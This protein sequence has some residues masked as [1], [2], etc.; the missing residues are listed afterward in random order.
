MPSTATSILDGLSTSVAIKAPCRTATTANITLSGLQTIDSVALAEGERV[1]VKNQTTQSQN[2]I[3]AAS[4]GS[5]TRTKDFDGNRDVRNGTLVLVSNSSTNIYYRVTTSDPITIGTTSI[6]FELVAGALTQGTIGAAFYPRSSAEASAG[7]TP[8]NYFYTYGHVYR[9]GTNATPGTTD[10]TSAINTA[11]NVCREGGYT[12]RLPEDTCLVSSS[13]NFSQITVM[14]C[15]D[16]GFSGPHIQASSAQFNV[17]T[18]VGNCTFE[19]FH[20]DGGWDRVTA[21]QSGDVFN[22]D[23]TGANP[24]NVAYNI[25]L[26]N[27]RISDAKKRAV[28]WYKGGYGS[29]QS[30]AMNNVGL[31]VVEL[32][33]TAG[34]QCTTIQ[35]T[36]MTTLSDADNG[37][38]L[39]MTECVC[40]AVNGAIMENTN[41][42]SIHSNGNRSISLIGLY[43]EGTNGN[44]ISGSTSGGIGLTIAGCFGGVIGMEDL[45]NWEDV[46][47]YGN[48]NLTPFAIPIGGRISEV[49]GAETTTSTTGGVS[50]TATSLAL[51]IGTWKVEADLQIADGG[52]L[53]A[54]L[55]LACKIT[56]NVA[57]AG[58]ANATNANFEVGAYT[59]GTAGNSDRVK[60]YKVVR[61]TSATT[62]YL[63]GYANF[64]AGTLAYKGHLYAELMQ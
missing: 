57:D 9:Y 2:G 28:Y 35:I 47:I 11:A 1:L 6:V 56:T 25:H 44:F 61:L 5:W 31:H 37:D 4:T 49:T 19:N 38:G 14:G 42:V 17:I 23:G 63:R 29:I 60:A 7:V 40:I 20:V 54:S 53:S 21:G 36:G 43:Q 55:V 51:G 39:K 32:E 18:S 34:V 45:A 22:F 26:R 8:T 12:L 46:H 62:V 3:Y 10:M 64:A 13:L 50:F 16:S 33:G 30:C 24:S 27:V 41:G 52:G 15:D 59:S 48:G 58:L